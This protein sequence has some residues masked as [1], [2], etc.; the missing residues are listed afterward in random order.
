MLEPTEVHLAPRERE[1]LPQREARVVPDVG[2]ESFE[3]FDCGVVLVAGAEQLRRCECLCDVVA[4]EGERRHGWDL[5]EG[6]CRSHV[7]SMCSLDAL[8]IAETAR[9]RSPVSRWGRR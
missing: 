7:R 8:S 9:P 4:H 5:G 3:L 1:A 2:P 6:R